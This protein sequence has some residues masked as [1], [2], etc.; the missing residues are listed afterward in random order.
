MRVFTFFLVL[1]LLC[2]PLTI[3]ARR[4]RHNK[5]HRDLG[6]NDHK[7]GPHFHDINYHVHDPAD[8]A[9]M[10]KRDNWLKELE[11]EP[12]Q[13]A[14]DAHERRSEQRRH[15]LRK[16]LREREYKKGTGR[17]SDD[18]EKAAK[19]QKIV[20]AY[21][22]K[23][24][25]LRRNSRYEERM[26]RHEAKQ[27]EKAMGNQLLQ[28]IEGS[29]EDFVESA[30]T[31]GGNN[32]IGVATAAAPPPAGPGADTAAAI[33]AVA[34]SPGA[35]DPLQPGIEANGPAF[36]PPITAEEHVKTQHCWFFIW[37]RTY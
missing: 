13:R 25:Y 33:A 2:A 23:Q 7:H 11:K 1:I 20:D 32:G 17:F 16:D 21:E 3:A 37:C 8:E 15:E 36:D 5:Y 4:H 19:N 6:D 9:H 27:A 24:Q 12:D 10:K 29:K 30:V 14:H 28:D 22:R 31:G 35:S 18:D 26:A 34:A